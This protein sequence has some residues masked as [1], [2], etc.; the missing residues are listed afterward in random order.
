MN[1]RRT[2]ITTWDPA[3]AAA[4]TKLL[5]DIAE[6]LADQNQR[7]STRVVGMAGSG[8]WSGGAH[9]AASAQI[10]TVSTDAQAA[11]DGIRRI[12]T[13]VTTGLV[14]IDTAR[15]R[16]LH[17]AALA[18]ADGILVADNWSLMPLDPTAEN[19]AV[20]L[21]EWSSSISAGVAGL[22]AADSAS[23]AAVESAAT[24]LRQSDQGMYGFAPLALIGLGVA[25]EAATA[26]LVAAGVITGAA[27]IALLLEK[28]GGIASIDEILSKVPDVFRSDD[29][30]GQ[31]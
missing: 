1:Y 21:A 31:W 25:V 27:V 8:A 20:K 30:P 7:L 29:G 9:D 15:L 24:S 22:G 5:D 26:A 4:Q 13:A 17:L 14:N 10:A 11:A 3:A 6:R 19:A 28:F 2:A 16:L 18:E 23:A 12:R